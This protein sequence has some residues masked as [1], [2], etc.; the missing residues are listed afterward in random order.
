MKP[1]E[2]FEPYLERKGKKHRAIL[3][4]NKRCASYR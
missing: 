1:M 3:T 4:E 2:K